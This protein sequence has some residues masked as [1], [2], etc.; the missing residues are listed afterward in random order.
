MPNITAVIITLNEAINLPRCLNS[1]RG[2]VDEFV[3]YDSGSVDN[4]PDLAK[5]NGAKVIQGE[6]L[7]YTAT[8]NIANQHAS[9]P[10]ILSID[11]DEELSPELQKSLS[12]KKDQLHGAYQFNRLTGINGQWIRH[13]GWHPDWKVRLF[14]KDGGRWVGDYVHEALQIEGHIPVY[15]LPGELLHHSY[16]SW[17]DYWKR[18]DHYSTLS[19]KEMV[20]TGRQV[21][22]LRR[23]WGPS[24]VFF[25]MFWLKGGFRDGHL[26]WSVAKL[27]AAHQRLKYLKWQEMTAGMMTE[28][29][30]KR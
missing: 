17:A 12:R 13:G 4:T 7:G 1:L 11:A 8:K 14:P 3:V 19:A 28:S 6:W 24:W 15:S 23:V 26:G 25:R 21:N 29:T 20:A 30:N 22:W 18:I 27:S 16:R 10:Y 5:K 9:H 2:I